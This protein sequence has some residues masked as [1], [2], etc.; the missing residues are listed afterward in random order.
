MS[1]AGSIC[2]PKHRFEGELVRLRAREPGD[3]PSFYRWMNDARVTEHLS[4]V[5]P[6]SLAGEREWFANMPEPGYRGAN[7]AIET[8]EG[9][10]LIGAARIAVPAAENR[11][12]ELSLLVG[13]TEYWDGGYGTDTMRVLCDFAFDMMN[14]HRAW[15][16]VLATNARAIHVYEKLG[17]KHEAR[18]RDALYKAGRWHDVLVMGVLE[19]EWRG[20][21]L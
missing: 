16:E 19:D 11:A 10:R 2:P 17:F 1:A 7:L 18:R 3:E 21:G 15:L 14:L 4:A 20:A 8:R 13:E 6:V 12:G 9:R 5:Y